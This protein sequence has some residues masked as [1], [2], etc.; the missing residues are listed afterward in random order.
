M[1]T[2][3]SDA[4]PIDTLVCDG[5]TVPGSIDETTSGEARFIAQVSLYSNNLGVAIAQNTFAADAGGEIAAL[6]KLLDWVEIKDRL[7]Y[8]R[9]APLRIR[10]RERKHAAT[11]PGPCA[12][13]LLRPG[14]WR[15]GPAAPK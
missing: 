12:A 15:T 7:T 14:W 11:S 4:E 10:K 2:Q 1:S 8:G 5:K 9:R 6:S 3:M 13:C